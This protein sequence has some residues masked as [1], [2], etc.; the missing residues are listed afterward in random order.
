MTL[1]DPGDNRPINPDPLPSEHDGYPIT[2]SLSGPST[3]G[4]EASVSDALLELLGRAKNHKGTSAAPDLPPFTAGSYA[5]F[6]SGSGAEKLAGSG[7]APL[8]AKARGYGR[9]DSSNF[10]TE[11][12]L[13]NIKLSTG[14]GKRLQGSLNGPGRDGLKMP[15]FSLADITESAMKSTEPAPFTHQIRPSHPSISAAGKPI[16]YEFPGGIGTPLDVHPAVPASWIDTT[17]VV[18]ITE[19]LLK[20]D[21]ALTAYLRAHGASWE[22]LADASEGASARLRALLVRIPLADRILIISIAG[23]Y[24]TTQNPV[25]WRHIKLRD[26]EVW[27]GFDAD[28]DTNIFV[29]RA[30]SKLWKELHDR[31]KVDRVRLVSPKVSSDS[32]IEKAGVDDFLAKVGTWSDLLLHSEVSLPEAPDVDPE[33][34]LGSWRVAPDGNSTEVCVPVKDGPKGEVS[35]LR[36][37]TKFP[38]GGR[39]RATGRSRQPTAEEVRTGVFDPTVRVPNAADSFAELE[40]S[41]RDGDE[42]HTALVSGPDRILSDLPHE[43]SSAGAQLDQDLISLPEWPPR[44]QDAGRFL[45]AIKGHRS[46]EIERRVA[47]N[48]MGWVPVPGAEPVFLIG[49]QIIGDTRGAKIH[50]GITAA[51]LTPLEHY[52]VGEESLTGQFGDPI[53]HEQVL[54]HLMVVLDA[55]VHRA[56][57]TERS[58]AAI[59]LGGALRPVLPV[60]PLNT[61][62][63]SGKKNSGKSFAALRM[64]AF[65][66]RRPTAWLDNLPGSVKDT[67]FYSEFAQSATPIWVVDDLAPSQ[68]QAQART[69]EAKV[70]DQVRN[71]FNNA[72]KGRMQPNGKARPSNQPVAQLVITA[73]NPLNT[74]S[75]KERL[76]SASFGPGKLNPSRESTD[77]LEQ[78]AL[79]GG[80]P[81]QLTTHLIKFV[82]HTAAEM[83]GW[84]VYVASL[85]TH[86]RQTNVAIQKMMRQ[87]GA[88]DGSL[89]RVATL[90]TDL[91]I[92][93]DLL[94]KM[95]ATIGADEATLRLL[96]HE[97][98]VSDLIDGMLATHH[99]NEDLSPGSSIIHALKALMGSGKAHVIN[100]VSPTMSPLVDSKTDDWLLNLALG[101]VTNAGVAGG[102]RPSGPC[103]GKV[104]KNEAHGHVIMFDSRTA[105]KVA[106]DAYPELLPFGQ[107]AT[108]IWSSVWEEG[109]TPPGI[110]RPRDNITKKPLSTWKNHGV[111]GVPILVKTLVH[112]GEPNADVDEPEAEENVVESENEPDVAETS[113]DDDLAAASSTVAEAGNVDNTQRPATRAMWGMDDF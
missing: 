19:G 58:T 47:W 69:E 55:Y 57:F 17:P 61:I 59:V 99:E 102:L 87:R 74:P 16:K 81:A 110:T 45:V 111:S 78:I 18:M 42:Q 33:A 53:Y 38:F 8:V 40:F 3:P 44:G 93:F 14:Q 62:F 68:V 2:L 46:E 105:F 30:A 89:K 83:T 27:I 82:L 70:A 39:I 12:R 24:N 88:S 9:I 7:V 50:S 54:R 6:I 100:A 20:G 80:I 101:W 63:F 28:L 85:Q 15:W 67:S 66:A 90:A 41:W 11:I 73:E 104:V 32:G 86:I 76:I 92:V 96:S 95:A 84:A 48:R 21:S 56:P 25:D 112:F 22:E 35:E 13:M 107:S 98:V 10:A 65:W 31:E 23:I 34:K 108:V 75:A 51:D 5:G 109:L 79:E 72:A 94:H 52:G 103:I 29:W 36:W 77:Y 43:W 113:A 26:R 97:G 37:V 106:Q 60:R 49:D 91:V 71:Q 64:M 4:A 1:N